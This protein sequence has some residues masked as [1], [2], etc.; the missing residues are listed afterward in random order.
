MC[1]N[2]FISCH[3]R[4]RTFICYQLCENKAKL[5]ALNS[6]GRLIGVTTIEEPSPGRPKGGR[7]RLIGVARRL[8]GVIFTVF[9]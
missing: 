5:R 4:F 9:N 2:V 6:R 8:A 7:G 3:L 1:L